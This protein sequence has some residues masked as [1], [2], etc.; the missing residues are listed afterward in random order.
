MT[1]R[2]QF[3]SRIGMLLSVI[4]VAVGLG[5]VWRFP[6]MMG[7]Y[8][9]SAF[10]LVYLLFTLLLAV[11]ALSAE[12]ALGRS[13]G[14]GL[15]GAYLASCGRRR[16]WAIAVVLLVT[17]LV[18]D[19]YYLLVMAQIVMTAGW[20]VSP[21]FRADNLTQFQN[22]LGNGWWQYALALLLLLLSLWV[23]G[24]GLNRGIEAISRYV[25]PGFALVMLYLIAVAMSLPG[26]QLALL[27]FLR[28]DFAAL[29]TGDV[30]AALGQAFFSL[31]LGGTFHVVYGSYARAQQSLPLAAVATAGGDV[32]A[33]LLAALFIVPVA[34]VF[35]LDLAQ[36][37]GLIFDTL[38]RL[39]MHLPDGGL[40]GAGFLLALTAVALLSNIAALEVAAAAVRER[41]PALARRHRLAVLAGLLLTEAVL[42]LPTA[43]DNALIGTLDLVFGSGMQL[44]GGLLAVLALGWG[45]GRL[46]AQTA[47]FGDQ[48]GRWQ[49]M[50][51]HWLRW[52]VPLVI[53]SVLAGWLLGKL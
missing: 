21:G 11:P 45:L 3:A 20:A 24:R 39:F 34:L 1:T 27:A 43:L 42:M 10:L 4:G 14:L 8:G 22:W 7:S 18:A 12:W 46:R 13:T 49:L 53:L 33:A 2:P 16:G 44:L 38:P 15:P 36:G 41:F 5:N 37:P 40:L 26:A 31:G 50:Y 9:G 51:V 48:H 23:I 19:S 6:Y 35:S 29:S 47:L 32:L 52:I 30:F 25:M 28:P 17:V